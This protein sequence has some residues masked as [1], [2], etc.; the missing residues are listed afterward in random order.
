MAATKTWNLI[1]LSAKREFKTLC[2]AFSCLCP[3]TEGLSWVPWRRFEAGDPQ[4]SPPTLEIL[5]FCVAFLCNLFQHTTPLLNALS[6]IFPCSTLGHFLPSTAKV[7]GSL[8]V[9]CFQNL[10]IHED[11]WLPSVLPFLDFQIPSLPSSV[12]SI[13]AFLALSKIICM[14]RAWSAIERNVPSQTIPSLSSAEANGIL[15]LP[16]AELHNSQSTER[17]WHM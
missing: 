3:L 9:F 10:Y 11:K 15:P 5:W 6:Q 4:R 14:V 16:P 2:S 7:Q 17:G 13:F 8:F 1:F 12:Y